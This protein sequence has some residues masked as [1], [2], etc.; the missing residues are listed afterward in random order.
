MSLSL[1]LTFE[2]GTQRYTHV[3]K[4]EALKQALDNGTC[5]TTLGGARRDCN[6]GIKPLLQPDGGHY[7]ESKSLS[8]CH[9]EE[10]RRSNPRSKLII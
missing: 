9:C 3:M 1:I 10:A 4:T 5:D 6:R 7:I 8:L 2:H